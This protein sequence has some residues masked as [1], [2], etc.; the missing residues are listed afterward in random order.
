[1]YLS[2]CSR[3]NTDE[4]FAYLGKMKQLCEELQCPNFCFVGD[5]NAGATNTFA[6]FLK[7]FC[8]ENDFRFVSDYALLTPDTFTYISDAHNTTYWIDDF[9][10]ILF[11]ATSNV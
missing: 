11:S 3:A 8:V 10:F 9:V 5:F 1:M 2:Y 6:G 4:F 7:H